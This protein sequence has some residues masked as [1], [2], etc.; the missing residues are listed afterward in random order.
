ME[1]VEIMEELLDPSWNG[2]PVP[3]FLGTEGKIEGPF[4]LTTVKE[5][6]DTN[7]LAPDDL[8]WKPGFSGWKRCSEADKISL[9]FKYREHL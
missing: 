1:M 7:L 3:W 2:P 8:V 5:R 6:I 9:L 4:D